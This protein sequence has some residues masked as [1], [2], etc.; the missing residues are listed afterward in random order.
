MM[1]SCSY[2]FPWIF[3]L[4]FPIVFPIL[5]WFFFAS[6]FG[7]P[8]PFNRPPGFPYGTENEHSRTKSTESGSSTS[9]AEE[10]LDER[11]ARGEITKEEYLDLKKTLRG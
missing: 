1:E 3:P 7:W 4:L 2:C 5:F 10:I 9:S 11:L 8:G 6:R